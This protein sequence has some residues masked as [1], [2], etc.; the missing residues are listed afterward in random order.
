MME[1]EEKKDKKKK[2]EIRKSNNTET[3][4]LKCGHSTKI[5]TERLEGI[6]IRNSELQ[7]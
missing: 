6:K 2:A 5:Q 7:L 1:N 4:Q 3:R